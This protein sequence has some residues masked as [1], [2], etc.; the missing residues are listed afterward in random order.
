L[1]TARVTFKQSPCTHGGYSTTRER[2]SDSAGKGSILAPKS[3]ARRHL[4]LTVASA[5]SWKSPRVTHVSPS[6]PS[7]SRPRG[8]RHCRR[9]TYS[10]LQRFDELLP[11][12]IPYLNV[13]VSFSVATSMAIDQRWPRVAAEQWSWRGGGVP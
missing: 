12:V 10:A 13:D 1:S 2:V 11:V 4:Q 9:R 8:Y 6:L 7:R 3:L 5:V